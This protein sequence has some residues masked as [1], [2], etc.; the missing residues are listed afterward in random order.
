M[1]INPNSEFST[2]K[3]FSCSINNTYAIYENQLVSWIPIS[4]NLYDDNLEYLNSSPI[5]YS[6]FGKKKIKLICCNT[7]ICHAITENLNVF[8]WGIDYDR[9]GL[10]GMGKKYQNKIPVFNK[11]LSKLNISYISMGENHCVG[12]D[13]K[14]NLYVWGDNSYGQIGV[15]NNNEKNY[16]NKSEVPLKLNFQGN[17]DNF[18]VKKIQCGKYFTCGITNDGIVFKIGKNNNKKNIIFFNQKE[19]KEENKNNKFSFENSINMNKADDVYCSDKIIGIV[20]IKGDL[21]LFNEGQGLFNVNININNN[22]NV[23]KFYNMLYQKI[24]HIFMNLLI[25]LIKNLILIYLIL[26]KLIMK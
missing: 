4:Q 13:Y 2:I 6:N 14:R 23:N 17:N 8:S 26:F 19:E 16:E 21:L 9:F 22:N 12:M 5:Y 11:N 24:I 10:L 25:I 20:T 7:N 1:I 3:S 18:R 15:I